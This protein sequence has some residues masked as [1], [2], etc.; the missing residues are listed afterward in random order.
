MKTHAQPIHRST[1]MTRLALL[2]GMFADSL[3]AGAALD[4]GTPT[5]EVFPADV[6]L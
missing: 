3:S 5:F 4:P 2:A 6:N 1:W